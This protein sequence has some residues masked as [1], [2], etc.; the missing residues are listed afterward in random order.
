MRRDDGTLAPGDDSSL[1]AKAAMIQLIKDESIVPEG[2]E[3]SWRGLTITNP[4]L[5]GSNG[6]FTYNMTW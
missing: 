6:Q 3:A 1:E 2:G 4:V 5:N